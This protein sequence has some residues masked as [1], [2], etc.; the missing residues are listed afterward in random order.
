MPGIIYMAYK[1]CK[2]YAPVMPG[3]CQI[4]AWHWQNTKVQGRIDP[5][6]FVHKGPTRRG[7]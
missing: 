3:I 6:G 7:D 1:M 5:N 2:A 4:H